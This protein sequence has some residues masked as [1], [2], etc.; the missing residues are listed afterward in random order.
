MEDI[1]DSSRCNFDNLARYFLS[2]CLASPE[3]EQLDALQDRIEAQQENT[4]EVGT[5]AEAEQQR[6]QE[7]V[8]R[9]DRLGDLYMRCLEAVLDIA[10]N[11]NVRKKIKALYVSFISQ[12]IFH[13]NHHPPSWQL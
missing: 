3:K 4:Q 6:S 7:E 1:K 13:S 12:S 10:N 11:S 9:D 8:E 2:L 5:N